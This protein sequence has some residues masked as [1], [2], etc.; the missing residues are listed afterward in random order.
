VI[1]SGEAQFEMIM[2]T[3]VTADYSQYPASIRDVMPY[4]EGEVV[5]LRNYW[6]T[7]HGKLDW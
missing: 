4:I 6:Q 1:C 3:K 7:Q 2:P 5:E